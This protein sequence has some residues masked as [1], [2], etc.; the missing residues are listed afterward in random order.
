MID[1]D[2][3][4]ALGAVATVAN[5]AAFELAEEFIAFRDVDL[6]RLPQR[7]RA[8]RRCGIA[9]AILA[10]AV[11]HLQRLAAHLNLHR[12]A[13]TFASMCLRHDPI[14]NQEEGMEERD[15]RDRSKAAKERG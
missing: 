11:P 4:A 15:F 1:H 12:S 3:A 8:H 14:S 2:V 13:V 10:M 5:F 7:E 9:S 6:I